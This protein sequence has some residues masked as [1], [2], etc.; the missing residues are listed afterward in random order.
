MQQNENGIYELTETEIS[1]VTGGTESGHHH[2][3]R[4][5]HK[6]LQEISN[7]LQTVSTSMNALETDLNAGNLDAAKKDLQA[8]ED[9]LKLAMQKFDQRK[10][11]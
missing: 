11:I 7:N 8:S 1:A 2:L 10:S 4:H 3:H 9:A 6:K 5:K